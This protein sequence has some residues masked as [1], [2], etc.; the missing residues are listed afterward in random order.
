MMPPELKEFNLNNDKQNIF[1]MLFLKIIFR[2]KKIK[3]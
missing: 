2:N 1:M 3:I